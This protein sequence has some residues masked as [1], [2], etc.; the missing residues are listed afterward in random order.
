[1]QALGSE[2]MALDQVEE[3][4]H[5]EGPVA[6]LVGQRRQWQ[7]DPLSLKARTLAIERMCMP[8]LSN[9]IVANNC[10]PMKPRGVAW[11]G[12][13][14]GLI[15]SQSRHVNFS[16]TV[17]MTLKRRWISSSVWVTSSDLRQPRSA[18]AGAARRSVNDDALVFDVVRPGLR[19]GR[20]RLKGWTFCVFAT[21]PARQAH[22]RSP[23][24]RVLRA[25][26]PTARSDAP[27]AALSCPRLLRVQNKRC[28]KSRRAPAHRF[29]HRL[30]EDCQAF[31]QSLAVNREC[32][33]EFY[34]LIIWSASFDH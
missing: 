28:C 29:S 27:R 23:W 31:F 19:T 24:W 11:N 17:S 9:R 12:D 30:L 25:P 14:G 7:V 21:A 26:I 10:G 15:F 16:C 20:L 8:N 4:H 32:G 5:G 3:R 1:M 18:A 13:G 33:Q 34:H 22:P 6:D 2:H